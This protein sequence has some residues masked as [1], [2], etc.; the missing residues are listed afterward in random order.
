MAEGPQ[1]FL[2]STLTTEE[3]AVH[4]SLQARPQ[5]IEEYRD[6]QDQP[7]DQIGIIH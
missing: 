5:W 3:S 4:K 6:N 1:A 7:T 2:V